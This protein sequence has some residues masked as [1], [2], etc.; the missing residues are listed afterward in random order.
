M[1]SWDIEDKTL[2]G[3]LLLFLALGSVAFVPVPLDHLVG[4]IDEALALGDA[5][6]KVL[7]VLL[8]LLRLAQS[9]GVTFRL[10]GD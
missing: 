5:P 7:L 2:A 6:S 8:H 9:P 3:M 10:V 1:G 4:L